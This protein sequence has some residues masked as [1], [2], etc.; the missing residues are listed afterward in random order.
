MLVDKLQQLITNATPEPLD[1]GM[2]RAVTSPIEVQPAWIE[3]FGDRRVVSQCLDLIDDHQEPAD[4][5]HA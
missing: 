2:H 3:G 4:A 1:A 5:H